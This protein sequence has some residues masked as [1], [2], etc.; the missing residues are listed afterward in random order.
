M[1]PLTSNFI[2]RLLLF[3]GMFMLGYWLGGKDAK[4]AKIP[5]TIKQP[6]SV[7]YAVYASRPVDYPED[8]EPVYIPM[9]MLGIHQPGDFVYVDTTSNILAELPLR[10]AETHQVAGCYKKVLLEQ[11]IEHNKKFPLKH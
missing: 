10:D 7:E 2:V 3:F 5:A 11:R 9:D 4:S 1:I 8:C 6:D